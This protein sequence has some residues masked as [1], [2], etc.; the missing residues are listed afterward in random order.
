MIVLSSC[1]S[2]EIITRTD[3]VEIF[4][5]QYIDFDFSKLRCGS[6]EVIKGVTWME[7]VINEREMNA[8]CRADIELI[9]RTINQ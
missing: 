6:V 1:C 8:T 9:K 4:V 2:P 7:L 5:P 3:T